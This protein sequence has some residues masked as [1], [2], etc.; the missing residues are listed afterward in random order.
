MTM[1]KTEGH[2]EEAMNVQ[3]SLRHKV[4]DSDIVKQ[5]IDVLSSMNERSRAERSKEA[6]AKLLDTK[7]GHDESLVSKKRSERINC[8]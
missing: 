2:S 7:R 3:E 4:N 8:C 6:L 1:L 5:V